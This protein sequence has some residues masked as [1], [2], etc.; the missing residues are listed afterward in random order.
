MRKS[1]AGSS[2]CL[3]GVL[4]KG[5][6]GCQAPTGHQASQGAVLTLWMGKCDLKIIRAFPGRRRVKLG[7]GI[8]LQV[9]HCFLVLGMVLDLRPLWDF[10]AT[11]T[12]R[13]DGSQGRSW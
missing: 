7:V 11:W 2:D 10:R 8:W 9:S 6:T 3:Q 4:G 13:Q 12:T 5:T 1:L